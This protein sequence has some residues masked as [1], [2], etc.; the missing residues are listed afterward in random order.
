MAKNVGSLSTPF[1][2]AA[3]SS[4]GPSGNGV[5]QTNGYAIPGGQAGTPGKMP[6][7]TTVSAGT[8]GDVK[9]VSV[10]GVANVR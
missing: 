9:T 5:V 8:T 1:G 7:V 4:I 10:T 2:G 6:E 3:I